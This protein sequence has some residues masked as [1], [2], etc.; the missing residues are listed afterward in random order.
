VES[1]EEKKFTLAPGSQVRE[2]DF[3]LLFYSMYGPRLYFLNCG[4]Q[5]APEFFQG[6]CT[7]N[8]WL[9]E[10]GHHGRASNHGLAS[11]LGR[12]MGKGV[13]RGV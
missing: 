12:L 7:L 1:I 6:Q 5:L 11:S 4:E 2:E 3:G 10:H 13:I 9:E 8:K